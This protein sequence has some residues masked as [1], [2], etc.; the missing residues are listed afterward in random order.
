MTSTKE[1]YNTNTGY[2]VSPGSAF[3]YEVSIYKLYKNRAECWGSTFYKSNKPLIIKNKSIYFKK[4]NY[5][6]G[7]FIDW[8]EAPIEFINNNNFK[9]IDLNE[10]KRKSSTR[11]TSR[12]KLSKN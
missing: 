10:R 7:K 6:I 11:N 5:T 8:L 1:Y 3:L 2:I 4:D 12:R 9:L